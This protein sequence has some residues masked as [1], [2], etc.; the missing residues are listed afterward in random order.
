M[1]IELTQMLGLNAD[2]WIKKDGCC[3]NN[4]RSYGVHYRDYEHFSSCNT[5][6]PREMPNA[7]NNVI[8][9]GHTRIC[10]YCGHEVSNGYDTGYLCHDECPDENTIEDDTWEF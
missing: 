8:D 10:P 7:R 9:V 6:Y 2:D 4:I 5:S 1:Q 3:E